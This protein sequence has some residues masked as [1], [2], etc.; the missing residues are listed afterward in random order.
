MQRSRLKPNPDQWGISLSKGEELPWGIA[1]SHKHP[2]KLEKS[3]DFSGALEVVM[4]EFLGALAKEL[5]AK[6]YDITYL[7]R[8]DQEIRTI[9]ERL[10][11]VEN[12][13]SIIVPIE[14]F[15]PEPY[16]AIKPFHAVIE[17]QEGEYI[18]SFFDANINASGETPEEA[19]N[20][21][22]D[23]IIANFELF[24][25]YDEAHLGPI[26]SRKIKVLKEFI[27]KI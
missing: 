14:S 23:I 18:A 20:N 7:S 24:K 27:R 21:L 8:I 12:S 9:K 3:A 25:E 1:Q 10:A 13:T 16:E 22:K 2:I 6:L 26:P 17:L 4:P 15:A 19:V 5:S 11:A